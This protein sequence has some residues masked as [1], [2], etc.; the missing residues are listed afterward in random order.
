MGAIPPNFGSG[1]SGLTPNDSGGKPW[2]A[3]I[4][5]ALGVPSSLT[6]VAVAANTATLTASGPVSAV[7]ATTGTVTGGKTII[8]TGTPAAGEVLVTYD[9]DG[10]PTLTF[11]AGDGVTEA[12]VIQS[13]FPAF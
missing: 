12:A 7:Q 5:E 2:L 8:V 10:I 11:A 1:G 6:G 4:L 13:Q 3:Q 9:A